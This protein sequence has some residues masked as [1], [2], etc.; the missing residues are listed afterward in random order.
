[1]K[2]ERLLI[3]EDRGAAEREIKK[4][5]SQIPILNNLIVLFDGLDLGKLDE[6]TALSLLVDNGATAG[7]MF[8]NAI[9]ADCYATGNKNKH[10]VN[11]QVKAQE[12]TVLDFKNSIKTVLAQTER[13]LNY[14]KFSYSELD[15]YFISEQSK[16]AIA[17]ENKIYLYDE[18][19]IKLYEDVLDLCAKINSVRES[20]KKLIG[21][22]LV[23]HQPIRIDGD[24]KLI[25]YLIDSHS[26]VT[27]PR[28]IGI[29]ELKRQYAQRQNLI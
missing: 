12:Q 8:L 19:E 9:A 2:K 27:K 21:F 20:T 17:E 11:Q 16:E 28:S 24:L 25:K 26:E 10:F 14:S 22:D 23:G 15:G 18:K 4:L 7:E 5:E 6:K 3:S 29:L 13:S 1:M